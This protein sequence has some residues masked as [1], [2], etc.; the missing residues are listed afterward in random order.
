MVPGRRSV[1]MSRRR[2]NGSSVIGSAYHFA[3]SRCQLPSWEKANVDLAVWTPPVGLGVDA[4]ADQHVGEQ[5]VEPHPAYRLGDP[6]GLAAQVGVPLDQARFGR[7][8]V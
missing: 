4:V 1:S 2:R 8:R 5:R 6:S 7:G 3:S